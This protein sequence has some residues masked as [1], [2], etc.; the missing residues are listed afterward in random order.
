MS[1]LCGKRAVV[2]G[3]GVGGLSVAGALANSFERVEILERDRLTAIVG[4][5]S[6]TPQDRHPHALLAGGLRALDE[7]FP[8]FADD[9]ARAGAVSVRVAQDIQFE[10]PDF[11]VAP[12]RD[13]GIS[14]LCASRPLI[15]FVL[16]HRAETTAN[17]ALRPQCRVTEIVPAKTNDAVQGVRIDAG[18][19]SSEIIAADLVVDAS[20][21]GAL[22]LALLDAL[23]WQRPEVT[24]VGVDISYASAMVEI[25]PGAPSDWKLAVTF[26]DPPHLAWSAVLLPIEGNRWMVLV[27]NRGVIA[28]LETWESF[29]EACRS[30][31][32]PTIYDALRPAEPPG[33]IRHYGF[34]ASLW[35]HFEQLPGLPRGLL[36]VADALCRFNPVYGQGMSV[37]A[38]QARL[39][40][41]VSGRVLAEADPLAALQAGFME[42]VASVLE[43]PWNMS[44]GPDLAFPSTRGS[45]PE[46]FEEAQQFEA[47]LFRAIVVDPVVHRALT[48][49]GQLLQPNSL[50]QT[51]DIMRRIGAVS[52]GKRA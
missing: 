19:G 27:A 29:L 26:P 51:P 25:P 3:A 20:G 43:T 36:P 34:P 23:D 13:F 2:V 28:R 39:L 35:R 17:I 46:K 47:A 15:E 42:E 22:T 7:I 24:E 14:L 4:S 1:A 50:L 48:E 52:A 21:R 10:R 11:G 18:S 31:I 44:T 45:R 12:K 5:R 41:D 38:K 8:G 40:Q 6:G 9:L 49:V 16:R 30:L 37:A 33:G 32:T